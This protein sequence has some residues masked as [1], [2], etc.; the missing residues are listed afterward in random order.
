MHC[1]SPASTNYSRTSLIRKFNEA[2]SEG[3]VHSDIDSDHHNVSDLSFYET[4]E[5]VQEAAQVSIVS[6]SKSSYCDSSVRESLSSDTED[7]LYAGSDVLL[8]EAIIRTLRV[9][10]KERWTKTTNQLK[11]MFEHRGLA[12]AIDE[13]R[14]RTA[15]VKEGH[16]TDIQDGT[17]YKKIRNVLS[18]RYDIVLMMN[19]DG[20]NLSSSSKQE[21]WGTLCSIVDVHPRKRYSYMLVSGVFVDKTKPNMNVFLKP[22]VD[23]VKVLSTNGVLWTHPQCGTVFTSKAACPV[24]CVDAPAKA[25]ILNVK[26]FS[27]RFGCNVCEQKAVKVRVDSKTCAREENCNKKK[28]T[29]QQDPSQKRS[30]TLRRFVYQDK[31]VNLR[32]HLR[33]TLQGE[34]AERRG[35]SRKGVLGKTVVAELPFL[36]LGVCL[37]AEY[38][39]LV[40]L[41]CVRYILDIIFHVRGPWCLR[42][43]IAEIDAFIR[44]IKV[45]YFHK[46]LPRGI[47]DLKYFKASELRAMLLYFSLPAFQKFLPP[48]YFQHWMLLVAA[49][50]LLLKEDISSNELDMAD[51]MLRC[52]VRDLG[53]LYHN[54]FYTYNIHNLL[55]VTLLVKRWGPLWATS[56]F[57]FES[58]NGFIT[59]H[60]H[61]T[62]HLGKELLNNIK[63]I[64]S[65]TVLENSLERLGRPKVKVQLGAAVD[66]E[67]LPSEKKLLEENCISDYCV[68]DRIKTDSDIFTSRMYDQHR[69][70]ANSLVEFDVNKFGEILHLLRD[71]ASGEILCLISVFKIKHIDIFFLEDSF[72]QLRH[73]LPIEDSNLLTLVPVSSIITKVIKAGNYLCLRPN[74]YE[75]NL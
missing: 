16:I 3:D 68:Y 45:P 72:Y 13:Q 59:S 57:D 17:E 65:L 11:F 32:T 29:V 38:M 74:H 7:E 18:G 46:R 4:V 31:E 24:I 39:H 37:S 25:I 70:R 55:H 21:L 12:S 58:Y 71:R 41:G 20:V 48:K 23:S 51:A 33:M 10:V 69:K 26:S 66:V 75:V 40:L 47:K 53:K 50:Y 63:I 34:L 28:K 1:E 6:V 52:F 5:L 35:K 73:L 42:K 56:A 30:T 62:K 61:G 8:T 2:E 14:R 64:Q 9:Y 15:D 54:K 44:A 43:H 36:D 49:I 67:L 60:V 22:F 19:S 27:H